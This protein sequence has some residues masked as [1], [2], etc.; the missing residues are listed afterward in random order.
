[1]R[2]IP[3]PEEGQ[4]KTDDDL[5]KYL[6]D[7][8]EIAIKF[9]AGMAERASDGEDFAALAR[10]YS[11]DASTRDLGGRSADRFELNTWPED[12]QKALSALK[13]GELSEPMQLTNQFFLFELAALVHVPLDEVRDELKEELAVRPPSAVQVSAYVNGA[14]RNLKGEVLPPMAE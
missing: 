13:V 9:L 11:H 10:T 12:I 4:L 8:T 5:K 3:T 2:N 1:M 14:T 6:A 7:Q